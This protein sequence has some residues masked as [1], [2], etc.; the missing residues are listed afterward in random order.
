MGHRVEYRDGVGRVLDT[1]NFQEFEACPLEGTK[2][3]IKDKEYIVI[4]F[5]T[6]EEWEHF[7]MV[8]EG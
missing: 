1:E 6:V 4:H 2:V 8:M 7:A 3:K 5:G